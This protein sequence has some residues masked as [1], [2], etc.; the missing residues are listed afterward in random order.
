ME[1]DTRRLAALLLSDIVGFVSLTQEDEPLALRLLAEHDALVRPIVAH[2]DGRVVK[3]M[4]DAHLVEFDSALDAVA[5]GIELQKALFDRERTHP[6]EA[7]RIRIGIHVG[8][9]T[10]RDGDVYGDTVNLLSRIAPLAEAGGICLTEPVVDQVRQQVGYP[11]RRVDF[12]P[13][14]HVEFP[15][16]VCRIELPWLVES[17][18]ART[19]WTDRHAEL[20][21]LERAIAASLNG[22]ASTVVICGEPGIGKTRL[23]EEAIR[24]AG[25]HGFRVLRGE[26]SQALQAPY[27]AWADGLRQFVLEAPSQLLYRVCGRYA[28][29]LAKLVPEVEDRV[30]AGPPAPSVDPVEGRHRLFEGVAQ[31]VSGLS[32]EVPVLFFLDDLQNADLDSLSLL[33]HAVRTW[34]SERLLFVLAFRDT[35]VD[36]DSTL[37]RTLSDLRRSRP[38]TTLRLGRMGLSDVRQLVGA[39][40]GA[41]AFDDAVLQAVHVRTGGNPFF[42]EELIRSW[43]EM[44]AAG[45]DK[46]GP[47]VLTVPWPESV[48]RIL[49][50]RLL[51]LPPETVRLLGLASV[52]GT[53]FRYDLLRS[54]AE[55][56]EEKLVEALEGAVRSGMLAEVRGEEGPARYAFVERQTPDLLYQDLSQVRA[57]LYHERVAEGLEL[58]YGAGA[59]EHAE[60]IGHHYLRAHADERAVT[61]TVW[62]AERAVDVYARDAAIRQYRTA[63]SLLNGRD[64]GRSAAILESLGDQE[65]YQ[66]EMEACR[67]DLDSAAEKF[68]Q[69]GDRT[70]AARVWL[71][72]AGIYRWAFYDLSASSAR[73]ENARVCLEGAAETP[74]LAALYLQLAGN[75]SDSLDFGE[76]RKMAAKSREVAERLKDSRQGVMVRLLEAALAPPGDRDET[77]RVLVEEI[78]PKVRV[79]TDPGLIRGGYTCL[80]E[81]EMCVEGSTRRALEYLEECVRLLDGRGAGAWAMDVK[82]QGLATAHLLLGE[83]VEADRLASATHAYALENYPTPDA[84]N[85]AVLGEVARMRGNLARARRLFDQALEL[86]NR[87]AASGFSYWIEG[88]ALRTEIDLGEVEAAVHRA[89]RLFAQFGGLEIPA[90]FLSDHALVLDLSVTA[91]LADGQTD[92]ARRYLKALRHV[93]AALASDTTAAYLHR[94]EASMAA[95]DG[96]PARASGCLRES[97]E[98]FERLGWRYEE[99]VTREELAGALEASGDAEGAIAADSRARALRR[100]MGLTI[101]EAPVALLAA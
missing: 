30:G 91:A 78:E 27:S 9:V 57:R 81:F 42:V 83:I 48:R 66:G 61:Y 88:F 95:A 5:C 74:Q 67:R 11:C 23:A 69:V 20:E 36:E 51:R 31:L 98:A 76:A 77:R 52:I 50:E 13:L 99:A 16:T 17:H 79:S 32:R 73:L 90:V 68:E 97:A 86:S 25:E 29:D 7:L 49:R 59:R 53:T 8:D 54:V 94:A 43:R 3:T 38:V 37:R 55:L 1:H 63:L 10:H 40:P 65:G 72:A 15:V 45:P 93:A 80:G 56:P 14:R 82:G 4:G 96:D 46:A 26:F 75:L 22:Q 44:G 64:P 84:P 89:E 6:G 28:T 71:K 47:S 58:L 70:A 101:P 18:L 33:G 35:E 39:I 41:S 92:P 100:G 2:H 34:K 19:P 21:Q 12:P 62:A 60:E 85:L 24:R 87:T